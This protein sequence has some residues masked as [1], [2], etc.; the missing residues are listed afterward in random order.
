M[1]TAKIGSD[2]A[3]IAHLMRRAGFGATRDQLEA[4]AEMGYDATVD[5]LLHPS[6][7]RY[8]PDDL[9]RRYHMDYA[10]LRANPTSSSHWIYRMVT[11]SAPLEEKIALLWHRVFATGQTK[12]IQGK[13]IVTQID[14]FR[15]YGMGS[16]R[17]LLI[18]LSRD[19][20]MILWLDNQD[21]HNGAI[22][23]NYG[24]EILELF[25]MG[26]GNYTE[27]DIKECSRAFTGWS[28]ANPEYMSIK[29]RNNTARPFGYIAWQYQYN[30]DDHDEG[31]K[32]FLGQT[33]NFNGEDVIDIICEQPATARFVA[34]HLYHY[35]VAD[36]PPVPQW[37][38][39]EPVDPEAIQTLVDAYFE[40]NYNIGAM[41]EVL[42]HSDFFKAES[43]RFARVKS[44]I[45]LVIG[46]LRLAGGYQHPTY[47]VYEASMASGYMGQAILNPP[48]VEGWQGG[49][50]W[51]TTGSIVQRVNYASKI[52]GDT[53][54][55]GVRSIIQRIRNAAADAPLTPAALVDLALELIGPLSPP[56]ESR[57][58][59][60][61]FAN[62]QG[63]LSPDDPKL[64][65][66]ISELLQ[67]IVA[68]RE[69][70]MA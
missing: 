28:I 24:R 34:R 25:S 65:Q 52:I 35:F 8:M 39:I 37:P 14:M 49:D 51:I 67:L 38:H 32:T 40:S 29:M 50:E 13:V 30:A 16:F 54:R 53:S 22:N 31:D 23:E 68:T 20:A 5:E 33:G 58:G 57:Q 43:A 42:F 59:L 61:D 1:A 3:L 9:L 12:L 10:D 11:T 69:Y 66:K 56:E 45:E 21:N 17:E 63:D 27:E 70:Q 64:E 47:D 26:V 60:V 19:P 48:T 36:E 44:P 55:P 62:A 18:Q 2:I 41:L 7:V 15:K 4:L 6:E 46:T